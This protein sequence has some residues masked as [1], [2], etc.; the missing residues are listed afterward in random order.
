MRSHQC[1]SVISG[2]LLGFC[3]A[4]GAADTAQG[5][6]V[7]AQIAVWDTGKPSAP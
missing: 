3:A 6:N 4:L 2:L 1:F 7:P 5:Q